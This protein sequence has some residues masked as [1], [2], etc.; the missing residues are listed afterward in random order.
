MPILLPPTINTDV[1]TPPPIWAHYRLFPH[2]AVDLSTPQDPLPPKP[3]QLFTSLS[4]PNP[5][6]LFASLP[7]PNPSRLISSQK[8]LPLT[9]LSTPPP[10]PIWTQPSLHSSHRHGLFFSTF[11]FSSQFPFVDFIDDFMCTG[12]VNFVVVVLASRRLHRSSQKEVW[13]PPWPLRAQAW[14]GFAGFACLRWVFLSL[15]FFCLDWLCCIFGLIWYFGALGF[16]D[17]ARFEKMVILRFLV[18]GF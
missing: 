16:D 1:S 8:S 11:S 9:D 14:G 7:L 3:S 12:F 2:L 6:H 5:S 10:L 17:F 18:F 13:V 4:L 15:R